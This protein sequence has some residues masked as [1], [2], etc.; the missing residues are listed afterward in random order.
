MKT[1]YFC[2]ATLPF[3]LS[4]AESGKVEASP[5]ITPET[6][7]QV[8]CAADPYITADFI[9]WK[10]QVDNVDFAFNGVGDTASAIPAP[11]GNFY[12]PSFAYEPGF[13]VGLGV[14]FK[15]DS[16]ICRFSVSK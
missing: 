4:A 2:V 5:V 12:H 13:K 14:K 6:C 1:I 9:Y 10:A 3:L 16:D 8:C 7:P 15:H 11:S